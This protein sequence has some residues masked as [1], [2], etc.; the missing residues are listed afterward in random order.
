M[1]ISNDSTTL[2]TCRDG[3]TQRQLRV[4]GTS[5]ENPTPDVDERSLR[6]VTA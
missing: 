2:S 5:L 4:S 1:V 6:L 3:G